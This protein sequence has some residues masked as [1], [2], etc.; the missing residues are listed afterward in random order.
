MYTCNYCG[1]ECKG[2]AQGSDANGDPLY[3]HHGD[4]LW[5]DD[6]SPSCYELAQWYTIDENNLLDYIM[7]IKREEDDVPK[8]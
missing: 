8:A 1:E 7:S 2:Y 6:G 4:D 5:D 3:F